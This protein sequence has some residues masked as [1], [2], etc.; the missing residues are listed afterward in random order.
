MPVLLRFCLSLQWVIE[1]APDTHT[2]VSGLDKGAL[3][4][5][6][7]SLTTVVIFQ[8]LMKL[9]ERG[10]EFKAEDIGGGD[11]QYNFFILSELTAKSLVISEYLIVTREHAFHRSGDTLLEMVCGGKDQCKLQLC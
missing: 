4:S 10:E 8:I 1:K 3:A 6:L 7:T 2:T 11:Q 9:F 5:E